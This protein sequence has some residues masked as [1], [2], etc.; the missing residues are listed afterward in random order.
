MNW[1]VC[2]KRKSRFRSDFQLLNTIVI[3]VL[4]TG[5]YLILTTHRYKQ[6][7]TLDVNNLQKKVKESCTA[8]AA[9]AAGRF[10]RFGMDHGTDPLSNREFCEV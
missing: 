3:K 5:F 8:S 2:K 1:I 6:E 4:G 10:G 9:S 7:G